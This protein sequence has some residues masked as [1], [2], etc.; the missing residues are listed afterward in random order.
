M[1]LQKKSL[2]WRLFE[3]IHRKEKYQV[4]IT[5]ETEIF[6]VNLFCLFLLLHHSPSLTQHA[7][8]PSVRIQSV[9]SS[10][11]QSAHPNF[12]FLFYCHHPISNLYVCPLGLFPTASWWISP[13]PFSPLL[14]H[15]I[16]YTIYFSIQKNLQWLT[17][18][19]Q[20]KVQTFLSLT[21]KIFLELILISPSSLMLIHLSFMCRKTKSSKRRQSLP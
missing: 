18:M 9:P 15:C 7:F 16:V 8:S 12:S 20:S 5:S 1:W 3:V 13:Q 14:I 11:D 17:S 6:F 21:L 2:S 19:Y 4:F 10:C